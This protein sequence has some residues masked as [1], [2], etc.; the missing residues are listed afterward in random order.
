MSQTRSFRDTL[1][2]ATAD[3]HPRVAAVFPN[4]VEVP[5]GTKPLAYTPIPQDA[6]KALTTGRE[7]SA[8]TDLTED[9]DSAHE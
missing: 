4:L 5:E 9:E 2:G 1:T 6:I 8:A 7:K 3:M